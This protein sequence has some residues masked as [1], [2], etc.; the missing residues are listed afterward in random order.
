M[1]GGRAWTK[2][3]RW[4]ETTC[5]HCKDTAES[6]TNC[7]IGWGNKCFG[8]TNWTQYTR[9]TKSYVCESYDDY[10]GASFIHHYTRRWDFGVERWGNC[11]EGKVSNFFLIYR[12]C[13]VAENYV[14]S[15]VLGFIL[16]YGHIF[17]R[18]E[19]LVG[20]EGVYAKMWRQQLE[21]SKNSSSLESSIDQSTEV[22]R[23]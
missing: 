6:A 3:E 1:L 10:C 5:C 13:F 19:H 17:F 20:Q 9:F 7:P 23:D 16:F 12:K 22:R 8:H 11:G 4:W 15:V 18:H 14:L 2:T 21:S